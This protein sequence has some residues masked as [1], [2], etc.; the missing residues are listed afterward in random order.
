MTVAGH[1]E[2][3]LVIMHALLHD[4]ISISYV[5]Y[6]FNVEDPCADVKYGYACTKQHIIMHMYGQTN[7]CLYQTSQMHHTAHA[8]AVGN[9]C[10]I[11]AYQHNYSLRH[12]PASRM[13]ICNATAIMTISNCASC[14]IW[15]HPIVCIPVYT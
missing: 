15:L 6:T 7:G 11:Y 9:G 8:C 5:E 14:C 4:V 2:Y 12:A 10:R 1:I 13:C 3:Y